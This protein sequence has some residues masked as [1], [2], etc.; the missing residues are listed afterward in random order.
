MMAKEEQE[1]LNVARSM[2]TSGDISMGYY[3]YSLI[4]YADSPEQLIKDSNT[5][6][7]ALTD[8]GMIITLSTLSLAA[9]YLAQLPGV[10]NLRPRLTMLN[11]QNFVD[12]NALHSIQ[13]GKRD[14]LPWGE[15]IAIARTNSHSPY[16]L[17]LHNS[18]IGSD[19]FNKKP[20]GNFKV[21]G[22]TGSGKTI[23]LTFIQDMLQ[24]YGK[25][26]IVRTTN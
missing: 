14:K 15:A 23:M 2:V 1:D 9:A 20:P 11:S 3:H 25:S 8:L 5:V 24:K 21:I 17:G 10:Y 16:Y 12:L 7:A 26:G 18:R 22:T 13:S 19:D 6:Q 4:V